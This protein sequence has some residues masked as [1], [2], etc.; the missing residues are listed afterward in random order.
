MKISRITVHDEYY[1]A[2]HCHATVP[3]SSIFAALMLYCHFHA[4]FTHPYCLA[5]VMLL[6]QSCC[7]ATV[8]R[9][10]WSCCTPLPCYL[11]TVMLLDTVAI[12]CQCFHAT[13][14]LWYCF[15]SFMLHCYCHSAWHYHAVLPF[16]LLL[17]H[18]RCCSTPVI[19]PYQSCCQPVS[20]Y[21]TIVL[22]LANSCITFPVSCYIA[23]GIPLHY[24]H[25]ACHC[26]CQK[27]CFLV[28]CYMYFATHCHAAR[29][30]LGT[31]TLTV[32][33]MSTCI[34]RDLFWSDS[35]FIQFFFSWYK[36]IQVYTSLY[37]LLW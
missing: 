2:C 6:C 33:A 12:L 28:S 27:S 26:P 23:S 5:I 10:C 37:M 7:F 9:L 24:R 17:G 36:D 29:H 25:A 15:T 21:V 20:H 3:L 18:S 30:C 14:L 31:W 34:Y 11:A 19:M 35:S 8:V 13:L 16:M 32:Q 1:D 22:L 4:T